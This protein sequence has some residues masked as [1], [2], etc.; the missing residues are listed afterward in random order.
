[1]T[2]VNVLAIVSLSLVTVIIAAQVAVFAA[3]FLLLR[4]YL[5]RARGMVGPIIKK[6]ADILETADRYARPLYLRTERVAGKTARAT[7]RIAD[8]VERIAFNTERAIATP[9]IAAQARSAGIQQFFATWRSLR[10][11]RRQPR[12]EQRAVFKAPV[13]EVVMGEEVILLRED[14]L[15][16]RAA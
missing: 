1:M 4:N 16:K 9:L 10:R 3:L 7:N 6:S 12:Q 13:E 2:V 5:N 8:N 14:A 15:K 11:Q